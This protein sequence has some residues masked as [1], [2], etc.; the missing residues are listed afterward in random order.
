MDLKV[1]TTH[2]VNMPPRQVS[3]DCQMYQRVNN[4]FKLWSF[5]YESQQSFE[6]KCRKRK[7]VESV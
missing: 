6:R 1:Q 3:G 7:R 5:H 2:T 4:I